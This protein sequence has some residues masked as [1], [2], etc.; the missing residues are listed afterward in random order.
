MSSLGLDLPQDP[1]TIEREIGAA[2][3]KMQAHLAGRAIEELV[4]L[5][6]LQDPRRIATTDLLFQLISPASEMMPPLVIL[7]ELILF[8]LELCHGITPAAAKNFVDCGIILGSI[9]NDY[10]SAYRMGQV[11]LALLHR[12]APT[13]LE[14]AVHF[15]FGCF[16]AHWGAHHQEAL[17]A[18]ARGFQRGVELGDVQ[19][20]AYSIAHRAKILFFA[21]RELGE[22]NTETERAL[23]YAQETGATGQ[24]MLAKVVQKALVRLRGSDDVVDEAFIDEVRHHGNAHVLLVLGLTQTMAS[25]VLGDLEGATR[26][27]TFSTEY[28][29]SVNGTLPVADYYLA[30]VLLA[31]RK[32]NSAA[33]EERE[34]L[35]LA[36]KEYEL[37][38][39]SF[40]EVS[41]ANFAHKHKLACAEIA[42]AGGAA[43]EEVLRLYREAVA[44]AGND[45]LHL[46]ALAHELEADFWAEK[47]HPELAKACV[48]EAYFLYRRWGATFK[49][50]KIE[51]G[52]AFDSL[53]AMSG[54]VVDAAL[55]ENLQQKLTERTRE[56]TER[57]RELDIVGQILDATV[58]HFRRFCLSA[59]Q[60]VRE[61]EALL[62]EQAPLD[63]HGIERLFRN[64]HTIKGNARMLGLGHLA[65][66]VH[67]AEEAFAQLLRRPQAVPD[68][69]P[70]SQAVLAVLEGIGEHE[71]ICERKLDEALRGGASIEDG[72]WEE[73]QSEVAAFR[74]GSLGA[75]EALA[76]VERALERARAV[77]LGDIVKNSSRMLPALAQELGKLAPKVHTEGAGLLLTAPWAR[78]VGDA[79]VHAFQNAI[80]HGIETSDQRER[81]GKARQGAI[82]V[83]AARNRDGFSIRFADDGPGLRLDELRQK[84]G[85]PVRTDEQIA[86][87]VFGAGVSTATRVTTLSGRGIGLDALRALV[88][89]EGGHVSIQFTSEARNGCRPFELVFQLPPGAA[90]AELHEPALRGAIADTTVW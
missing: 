48:L 68:R 71:R 76:R 62:K 26:W 39:R 82:V 67:R 22:V 65:D 32:W 75:N 13:P 77:P 55:Y 84:M 17:D 89:R 60:F 87:D 18:L 11:G 14:P 8:D 63:R 28:I 51:L 19:P 21:G 20:A 7:A 83:R 16:I 38:L 43:V 86:L 78:I 41:P 4:N 90:L 15:A 54:E 56:L 3:G 80:D 44:A 25:L 57:N 33:N 53:P 81:R 50:R 34:K 88:E 66:T 23:A 85:N 59:R 35:A 12:Q 27:D 47:G 45:F 70:L 9:L 31:V 30:K 5:P 42:R 1:A 10:A 2:I 72:A 61:S 37:K 58:P 79:F 64:M 36:V 49:L 46:R 69:H 6:A 52:S 40:A 74:A 29:G 24:G 73:I